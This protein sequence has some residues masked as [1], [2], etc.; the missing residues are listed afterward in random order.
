MIRAESTSTQY[1]LH[2]SERAKNI[3]FCRRWIYE[4]INVVFEKVGWDTN[5][6]CRWPSTYS[7]MVHGVL[8]KMSHCENKMIMHLISKNPQITSQE[9]QK[10]NKHKGVEV[11]HETIRN[12]LHACDAKWWS[13]VKKPLLS[14]KHIKKL[15]ARAE[16]NIERDW[17]V[18]FSDEA[19]LWA[20]SAFAQI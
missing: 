2:I 4:K 18:I 1:F 7:C 16:K 13:T 3:T 10:K 15:L 20:G 11:S 9:K 19:P 5:K 14:E 17:N 12:Q 6:T 8:R